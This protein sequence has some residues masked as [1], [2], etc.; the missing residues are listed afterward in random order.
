MRSLVSQAAKVV[1]DRKG[2]NE[3]T[4]I[5]N[6]MSNPMWLLSYLLLMLTIHSGPSLAAS[7]LS[8]GLFTYPAIPGIVP[9]DRFSTSVRVDDGQAWRPIFT[10]ETVGPAKTTSGIHSRGIYESVTG[11]SSSW[12]T[13][14]M[15]VPVAVEITK[16]SPGDIETCVIRPISRQLTPVI[17]DDKRSVSFQIEPRFAEKTTTRSK[18]VPVNVAVEIN[19]QTDEMIT[20]F[21]SPHLT[22]K[23][24][25]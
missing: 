18:Q 19:G 9:S 8:K 1:E 15:D 7:S 13:F 2:R 25:P 5:K 22:D 3:I 16:L 11:L 6:A 23:P 12:C 20:V 24:Q 14:E 17:S 4:T 21:A 10:M